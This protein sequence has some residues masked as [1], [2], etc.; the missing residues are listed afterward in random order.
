MNRNKKIELSRE[1][2]EK[3]LKG[4]LGK[5]NCMRTV[6]SYLLITLRDTPVKELAKIQKSGVAVWICKG[7][8]KKDWIPFNEN[9]Y[10][11]TIPKV[12]AIRVGGKDWTFRCYGKEV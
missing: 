11:H 6:F 12:V 4:K 2:E 5:V 7:R 1:I 8:Q 3:I 10:T 9:T